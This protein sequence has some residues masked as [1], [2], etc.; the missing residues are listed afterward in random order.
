MELARQGIRSPRRIAD[1]PASPQSFL[2]VITRTM[3]LAAALLS[4]MLAAVLFLTTGKPLPRG[5]EPIDPV[6]NPRPLV[7]SSCGQFGIKAAKEHVGIWQEQEL[8]VWHLWPRKRITSIACKDGRCASLCVNTEQNLFSVSGFFFCE[9]NSWPSGKTV[10]KPEYWGG[11]TPDV[12][13]LSK[14]GTRLIICT[15]NFETRLIDA[16]SGKRTGA[17]LD[18]RFD[19][20]ACYF[21]ARDQPRAITNHNLEV[22]DIA[23]QCPEFSLLR[24][25]DIQV[26]LPLSWIGPEGPRNCLVNLDSTA[27]ATGH[28]DGKIIL[29]SLQDGALIREIAFSPSTH[30]YPL[31]FTADGRFLAV[32]QLPGVKLQAWGW[33]ATWTLAGIRPKGLE[34]Q[35]GYHCGRSNQ[36]N[37]LERISLYRALCLCG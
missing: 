32:L 20:L 14:D 16:R 15:E 13:V 5:I 22:W 8:E 24:K 1:M 11:T 17:S 26:D 12:L 18:H 30:C 31:R 23:R 29:W 9:V 6:S 34:G 10:C 21:D 37:S 3:L 7:I 36:R 25:D 33:Q 28:Y 4:G 35:G 2:H 19:T 27:V